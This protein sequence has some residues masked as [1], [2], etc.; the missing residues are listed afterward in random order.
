MREL[1]TLELAKL[2]KELESLNGFYID[3][4]YEIERNRFR[5]K[6]SRKGEKVNLQCT[7]PYLINRTELVKIR[8]EATNFSIAVRK[9][10]V[11]SKIKAI[12][13]LNNDRILTIK[14]EK[15]ETESS[16]ILEM[17]GRGNMIITD[18]DNKIQL[19]YLVHEF[20]DRSLR[21]GKE[22]ITPKNMSI[23]V[24]D[25]RAI[26]EIHKSFESEKTETPAID[27]LGKRMGMGTMYIEEAIRRS[28]IER[29]TKLKEIDY[30]T[31]VIIFNNIKE[32]IN[33]CINNPKPTVYL[34]DDSIVNFALC[35]ISKYSANAQ[36]EFESFE[37]CL[38]FISQNSMNREEGGN[39]EV[40]RMLSSIEKQKKILASIDAESAKNKEMGDLIMNHMHELNS[41]INEIKLNKKADKDELQ[42]LSRTIKILSINM[43][44]KIIQINAKSEE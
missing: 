24:F 36:K 18:F 14:L 12:E 40:E 8:E 20:K 1:Y 33:Q 4:F 3:Q 16:I 15:E 13:Q 19:A 32:I 9:R 43:K 42:T 7:L 44:T 39:E 10:I 2:A 30:E 27:Y 6:I 5:F 35:K 11:G 28:K 25:S 37:K 26:S 41:I 38:D 17:F 21:P 31:R 29:N 22:Y 34:K 23:D